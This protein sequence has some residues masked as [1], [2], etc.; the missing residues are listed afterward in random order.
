MVQAELRV[1]RCVTSVAHFFILFNGHSNNKFYIVIKE[2]KSM[3]DYKQMYLTLLDSVETA[4]EMLKNVE[5]ACED[6]YIDTDEIA[7]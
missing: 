1:F 4:I 2:G 3:P 7:E 5:Q 6:I